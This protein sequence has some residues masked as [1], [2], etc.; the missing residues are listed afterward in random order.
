MPRFPESIINFNKTTRMH[1]DFPRI[2]RLGA[3][4]PNGE[5][6]PFLWQGRMMRL[7]LSDPSR[8]LDPG[9]PIT[10]LIRDRE[11]GEVL[12]R[13]GEGCYYYS[14]YK[15]PAEDT[16]RVLGTKR[17][18]VGFCGD[19]IMLFESRDL[20]HWDCRE[21]LSRPGWKYYNTSL[22][23]GPEGYVLLMEA[24]HPAEEV[25]VPFT[26]FFAKSKDLINWEFLPAE[27]A[28]SRNIYNGGPWMT[29]SRGYY[30]VISVTALPF[31]RYTNYLYRTKDLRTWEVGFYNP[32][33]SPSAEDRKVSPLACETE[34]GW[35][36]AIPDMFLA[37]SSDMD[38]CDWPEKGK[39]LMVYLL[40]NQMGDYYMAEAEYDG[41][42]ADFL[43]SYFI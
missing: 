1:G 15:D 13:F 27:N 8:G 6:S 28:F 12:S 35:T 14:L 20:I 30:Y 32:I 33:L 36:K 39:T 40:G 10:A 7:E 43:E 19:T 31:D 29:Y 5:A 3:V 41:S 11:T 23:R 25:G 38:L 18:D 4:S 17:G 2:H 16:V 37:S 22:T 21:L 34:S 26:F 9:V 42:L 24:S